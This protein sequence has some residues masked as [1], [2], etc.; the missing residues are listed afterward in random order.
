[1]FVQWPADGNHILSRSHIYIKK[2]E[3]WNMWKLWYDLFWIDFIIIFFAV[4]FCTVHRID[5]PLSIRRRRRRSSFKKPPGTAREENGSRSR[6]LSIKKWALTSFRPSKNR[7]RS[8][9]SSS[10]FLT[11]VRR[12]IDETLGVVKRPF[13]IINILLVYLYISR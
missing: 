1:M 13:I 2:G 4:I 12:I 5:V 6:V 8:Y 9:E 3:F 11:P 10:Y 7:K